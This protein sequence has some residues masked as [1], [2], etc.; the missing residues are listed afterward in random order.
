M[1]ILLGIVKGGR[2]EVVLLPRGCDAVGAGRCRGGAS[3]VMGLDEICR[4]HGGSGGED[5][6]CS[7]SACIQGL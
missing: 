7:S 3:V 6:T 4:L 5:W 2:G 1:G